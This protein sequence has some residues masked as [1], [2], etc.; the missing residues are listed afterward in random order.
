MDAGIVGTWNSD[1]N[2]STTKNNIGNVTMT[3]TE[4]GRLIYDIHERNKLQ[5]MNMTYSISGDSIISDQ[6]SHLAEQKTK[7]KLLGGDKLILEF[8]GIKTIFKRE[9]NK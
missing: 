8:D 7:F 2:D 9:I 3:F 5:R 4:D 1:I 6:Q